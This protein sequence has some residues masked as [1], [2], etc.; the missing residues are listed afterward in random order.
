M[1][2]APAPQ[3]KASD[4][5]LSLILHSMIGICGTDSQL[6]LREMSQ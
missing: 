2:F 6:N 1:R 3:S 5:E 4:N